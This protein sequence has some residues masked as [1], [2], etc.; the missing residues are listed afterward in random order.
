MKKKYVA[1]AL[2]WGKI[3]EYL[4]NGKEY[5]VIGDVDDDDELDSGADIKTEIKAIIAKYK[6]LSIFRETKD[7]IVVFNASSGRNM[8]FEAECQ[9]SGVDLS[10]SMNYGG[11]DYYVRF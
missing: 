5:P 2:F 6:S 3:S 9:A 11:K 4:T 10:Y 8:E 7:A 1:I